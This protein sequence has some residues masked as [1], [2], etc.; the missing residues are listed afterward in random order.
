M[1][2]MVDA[3][4]LVAS[5]SNHSICHRVRRL[6]HERH[7]SADSVISSAKLYKNVVSCSNDVLILFVVG[8]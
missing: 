3:N 6:V 5:A 7:D 4:S 1:A 8:M 2:L